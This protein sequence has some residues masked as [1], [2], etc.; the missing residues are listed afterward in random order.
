MSPIAVPQ[1]T[2]G[3][4]RAIAVAE[5]WRAVASAWLCRGLAA[6]PV[7]EPKAWTEVLHSSGTTA[8]KQGGIGSENRPMTRNSDQNTKPLVILCTLGMRG[9]LGELAPACAARDLAFTAEYASTNALLRRIDTGEH[10]DL[11][12][13]VDSSLGELVARGA[14]IAN[15]CRTIARSGVALAVRAGAPKPDIATVE[16]FTRA[17]RAARSLA[18]T[19]S[20]ASGIHFAA[21]LERLG[22]ADE[23]A[24]K[25]KVQDG[26]VGELAARGEVEI[27]VQQ[28]SELMPVAGIDIVGPLPDALQKMTVF[29]AGVFTT[30]RRPDAARVLIDALTAPQAE[31]VIRRKG[32]EPARSFV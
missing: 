4:A 18:Y 24:R 17:L 28:R 27:A 3:K 30:S 15:S 25:S 13:L 6:F 8:E 5:R 32:L 31:E 14:I 21:V 7:V 1:V 16:S 19:V 10:A 29:S 12:I 26:L 11:A 9:V 20:G 23:I 2:G 22:L